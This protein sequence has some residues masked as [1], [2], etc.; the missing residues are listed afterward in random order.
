MELVAE[1]GNESNS[2]SE[3][4]PCLEPHLEPEDLSHLPVIE[5]AP[6]SK[7]RVVPGCQCP[8]EKEGWHNLSREAVEDGA[9]R[10]C[11]VCIFEYNQFVIYDGV[12]D[13][14]QYHFET[15]HCE[16]HPLIF[17][18]MGRNFPNVEYYTVGG[19]L[20]EVCL[21]SPVTTNS[22]APNW[23]TQRLGWETSTVQR[24]TCPVAS[25][26]IP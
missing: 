17:V 12:F 25:Q 15:L 7:Y 1:P 2:E 16:G 10:G 3:T 13:G 21:S 6:L 24:S 22:E 4:E 19:I 14:G 8:N 18:V 9:S 23:T 5:L 11:P 26:P 20:L